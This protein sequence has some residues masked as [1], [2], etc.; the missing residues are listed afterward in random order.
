MS[1][2]K[3]AFWQLQP[4]PE[5]AADAEGPLWRKVPSPLDLVLSEI[6]ALREEVTMLREAL[7]PHQGRIIIG[8]EVKRTMRRLK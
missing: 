6:A 4:K 3:R 5:K 2:Q 8:D 7:L 1:E